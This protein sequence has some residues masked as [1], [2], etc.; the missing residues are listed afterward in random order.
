LNMGGF[1][2][3]IPWRTLKPRQLFHHIEENMQKRLGM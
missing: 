1:L 3:E 2:N